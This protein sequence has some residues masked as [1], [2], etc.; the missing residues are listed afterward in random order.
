MLAA[1]PR[2]VNRRSNRPLDPSQSPI[3]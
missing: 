3:T 2:R 1:T